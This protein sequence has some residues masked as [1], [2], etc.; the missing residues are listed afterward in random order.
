MRP[1]AVCDSAVIKRSDTRASGCQE[2]TET[3]GG[4]GARSKRNGLFFL[5]SGMFACL[6][7]LSSAPVFTLSGNPKQAPPHSHTP[8][9]PSA[10]ST[11]RPVNAARSPPTGLWKQTQSQGQVLLLSRQRFPTSSILPLALISTALIL[12]K[13]GGCSLGFRCGVQLS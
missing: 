11:G 9:P 13:V 7:C 5:C 1:T 2:R 4:G 6:F 8:P 12:S 3:P 10:P